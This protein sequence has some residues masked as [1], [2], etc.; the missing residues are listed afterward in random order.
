[1]CLNVFSSIHDDQVLSPVTDSNQENS[2]KIYFPVPWRVIGGGVRVGIKT[3]DSG[4]STT[5]SRPLDLDSKPDNGSPSAHVISR[6]RSNSNPTTL[7]PHSQ[8]F[9]VENV[10]L[11][12]L[13]FLCVFKLLI[14]YMHSTVILC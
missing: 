8:Q 10:C 9:K 1:M 6:K 14:S 13:Y 11:L 7:N 5:D 4:P 12:T 3:E 2:R